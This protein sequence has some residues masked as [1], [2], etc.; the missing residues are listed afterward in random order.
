MANLKDIA[1]LTGV[2]VST[3]SRALNGSKGMSEKTKNQILKVAQ[4]NN[5]IPDQ[6]ARALVG[7]GSKTIGVILQEI[8]SD[9]YTQLL[10]NIEEQLRK[11]GYS[12]VMGFTNGNF[13][14][15]KQYLNIF[16]R[17][18]V[19]GIILTG[20]M[21]REL[22]AY[23]DRVYKTRDTPITLIQTNMEY[24][25]YDYI[26]VDEKYGFDMVIRHLK[27]LGHKKIGFLFD[28][29]SSVIRL[30]SLK[31]AVLD[32]GLS[33][34][35]KFFKLGK[36]R[37]EQGGYLRMKELLSQDEVPTAVVA[38]YD[39]MAIG[40]INAIYEAGLRI[41]QDIS[42]V[43][44]DDIRESEYLVPPL[45]TV[46]PPIKA[47]TD[48]GVNLLLEKIENKEKTVIHQISLK[49]E[50]ILRNTTGKPRSN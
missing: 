5:Y 19:D 2:S 17:R 13:D 44:Y 26:I 46:S 43:G 33:F 14:I 4:E 36:E 48:L 50:L 41:P 27:E 11:N 20:Y 8:S 29:M 45:T 39:H 22:E 10:C 23:L 12:I 49:P 9:Y 31:A 47:M 3:V 40:A 18:K 21:Y 24:S 6:A 34:D 35:Q 15:E 37:F 32:N 42:L 25:N 1:K 28:E 38:S 30:Q 16:A 7:K